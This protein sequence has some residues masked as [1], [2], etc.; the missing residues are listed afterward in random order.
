MADVNNETGILNGGI[1]FVCMYGELCG[2]RGKYVIKMLY[3]G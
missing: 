3:E 1:F 2:G